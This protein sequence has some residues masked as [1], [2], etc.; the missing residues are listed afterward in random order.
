MFYNDNSLKIYY[1]TTQTFSGMPDC[2]V[3]MLLT[4]NDS[5][6]NHL[7]AAHFTRGF[8]M[9]A[10]YPWQ[11]SFFCGFALTRFIV[12]GTLTFEWQFYYFYHFLFH[13]YFD[14]LLRFFLI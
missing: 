2:D 12:I 14:L 3:L 13:K 8:W 4:L 1:A 9:Q 5:D 10:T 6:F 11:A 7:Y